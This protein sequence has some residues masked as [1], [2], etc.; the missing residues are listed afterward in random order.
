[1]KLE[2]LLQNKGKRNDDLMDFDPK[3]FEEINEQKNLFEILESLEADQKYFL[4]LELKVKKLRKCKKILFLN[5][6]LKELIP[7]E[8][9]KIL[10]SNPKLSQAFLDI[11]K[12]LGMDSKQESKKKLVKT[13]TLL[14][15]LKNNEN[16]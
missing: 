1:M 7:N 10:S 12:E 15:I 4:M 5:Q 2:Q 6:N 9:K 13:N 16:K 8:L 11:Q 3:K 14:H